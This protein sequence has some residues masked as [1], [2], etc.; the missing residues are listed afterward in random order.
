[1]FFGRCRPPETPPDRKVRR[2]P[3]SEHPPLPIRVRR[4]TRRRRTRRRRRPLRFFPLLP[5]ADNLQLAAERPL[6]LPDT[7]GVRAEIAPRSEG[8]VDQRHVP[9]RRH[10][11]REPPLRRDRAGARAVR[12]DDD[13]DARRRRRTVVVAVVVRGWWWR[14]RREERTRHSSPSSRY[15]RDGGCLG[16][17]HRRRP[18][19][20]GNGGRGGCGGG[21]G[22]GDDAVVEGRGRRP[23]GRVGRGRGG[24]GRG[25][26]SP[27]SRGDDD[28]RRGTRYVPRERDADGSSLRFLM[29]VVMLSCSLLARV[30]IIRVKIAFIAAH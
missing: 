5:R 30:I 28:E 25:R 15:R 12:R 6:P 23:M 16:R 29:A 3:S 18:R 1:M 27:R 11:H 24:R 2:R 8:G 20:A 14:R 9:R 4:R 10:G 13:D 21:E 26:R 22:A 17:G 7:R 19:R